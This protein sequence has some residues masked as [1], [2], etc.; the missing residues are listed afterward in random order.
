M[1]KKLRY[2]I[3]AVVEYEASSPGSVEDLIER[4]QEDGE[5]VIENVELLES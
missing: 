2:T 1:K 5:A 3:K 4:I